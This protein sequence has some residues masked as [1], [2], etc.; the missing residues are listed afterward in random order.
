MPWDAAILLSKWLMYLAMLAT[1]GAFL[2]A[3]LCS[4]TAPVA[5]S[6]YSRMLSHYVIPSAITGL[7]ACSVFFLLQVGVVNQ[8][9]VEGMLDPVIADILAQTALGDGLKWRLSGF[10]LALLAAL[11][12]YVRS[13]WP[14]A[15]P[16][17]AIFAPP[18]ILTLVA[19]ALLCLAVSFAVLGHSNTLDRFTRL[20]V[21]MHL[22]AVILWL[23]SLFP[24][25]VLAR[26]KNAS[27]QS[28]HN[29]M[30]QFGQA[31]WVLLA[32]LVFSGGWLLWQLTAGLSQL[33]SSG[34][35][36][37]LLVKLALV[38]GLLAMGAWHK[39]RLVPSIPDGGR[40]RLQR[41]IGVEMLLAALILAVTALLTT[42]TGP[43]L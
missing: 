35:G 26:D 38:T 14:S 1:P 8:R 41:S 3:W 5:G 21:V 17:P 31:A 43:A 9:G 36:R 28:V 6:A 29:V 16:A 27:D 23:G 30:R 13:V 11:V 12:M 33:F 22:M 24:L 10:F 37:L 32:A 20:M 34:Y 19:L 18:M 4:R 39:F 15:R 42:V 25:Y 40:R 2:V 7:L